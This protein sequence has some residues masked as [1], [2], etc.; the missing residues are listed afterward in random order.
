MNYPFEKSVLILDASDENMESVVQEG[1]KCTN[2][3]I[4]HGTRTCCA[5]GSGISYCNM[6]TPG[7]KFRMFPDNLYLGSGKEYSGRR[8]ER[9]THQSR[10]KFHIQG[11]PKVLN[12]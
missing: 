4:P 7:K 9:R 12:N 2:L 1:K 6:K 10:K 3:A 5:H 11:S 8:R